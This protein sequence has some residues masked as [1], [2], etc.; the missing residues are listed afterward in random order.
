MLITGVSGLLGNNLAYYFKNKYEILGLYHTNPVSI[1]SIQ[2]QRIDILSE[3]DFRNI[4]QGFKPQVLIHCASMTNVDQCEMNKELARKVNLLG[5]KVVVE[6]TN[7]DNSIKLIYISTDSVYDGSK[8]CFSETDKVKPL[9]YY[10][11][12][13]Y[14]GELE[15]LKKSNSLILRTNIFG[16]NIQDKKSF[17]EWILSEL[18]QKRE[19]KCFKDAY[20]SSIYTLEFARTIDIALQKNLNGI[21]NCGS[22]DSCSKYEFA[23]KIADCFGFNK[24]LITPIAI[25]D[26]DFKARR[27]ENL[28]LNISKL[29]KKSDIKYQL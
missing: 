6:S 18:K 25:D 10:G 28:I 20:F 13:K 1:E 24:K 26:F 8:G 14:E 7:G 19:I 22:S 2:T 4:V 11:L 21:Y 29:Q 5:T 16:W 12:S 17:G 9:N 15:C 23:V 27:G 3:A